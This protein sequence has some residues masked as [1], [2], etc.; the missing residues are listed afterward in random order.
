MLTDNE[1][2]I[3]RIYELEQQLEKALAER[4]AANM[5][6]EKASE[7]SRAA[8]EEVETLSAQL[9]EA[10]AKA[11]RDDAINLV[12]KLEN[13]EDVIASLRATVKAADEAGAVLDTER[14]KAESELAEFKAAICLKGEDPAALT[15]GKAREFM[16][17]VYHCFDTH[18]AAMA[19]K[20]RIIQRQTKAAVQTVGAFRKAKAESAR[21]QGALKEIAK[22]ARFCT[23]LVAQEMARVA[24]AALATEQPEAK[25][26][27]KA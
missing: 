2:K 19:D 10:K 21:Y 1:A 24:E 11:Y 16:E 17:A 25:E 13:A 15:P 26:G 9:K 6:A 5:A 12:D 7:T 27:E 23:S 8:L 3:G 4:D 22:R 18:E 14:K 20:D